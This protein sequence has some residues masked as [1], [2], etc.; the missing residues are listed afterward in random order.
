MPIYFNNNDIHMLIILKNPSLLTTKGCVS[1]GYKH[2]QTQFRNQIRVCD[3][4]RG[5]KM[6]HYTSQ[7]CE[8]EL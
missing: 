5:Q 3:R 7:E 8:R 6:I 2:R 4:F 1:L